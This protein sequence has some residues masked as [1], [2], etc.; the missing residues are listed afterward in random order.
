MEYEKYLVKKNKTD[1][2]S[3]LK[4]LDENLLKQKMKEFEV[5][6]IKKLQ[7]YI[8]ETF[9]SCLEMSI[10][11][12]FTTIYFE[13]LIKHE[14]SEWMSAYEQDIESLFVFVY[15]NGKNY[16]YYIPDELKEIINR[17]FNNITDEAKF[18]LENAANTPIIKD[19]N[20]LLETLT[21]DDLKS[22]GNLLH[23]NRLSK[24]RKKELVKII[25][26]ALTNKDK[27]KDLI[28]RFVDKEFDL[29]IDLMNNKGTIQ[30]NNISIE[31]YHFLYMVGLV[32]LF[33]RDNKFYISMT[34]DI[35][36]VIKK[37]NLNE[38]KK[39]IAENNKVYYMVRSMI[40]LYG[41]LPYSYLDY[42]YSLYY[43]NGKQLET[44]SNSLL[45]CERMDNIEIIYIGHEMYFIHRILNLRDTKPFLDDIILREKKI[46]K[47][48]IKLN[49]LLKYSDYN[50]YEQTES[51]NKLKKY[52]RE[53]HI[54]EDNI[55]NII[56][57]ISDM[58]RL[59]NVFVST[60]IEMFQEYGVNVTEKNIQEIIN[61]L[62]EIYNNSRIWVNN[63]WTPIEMRKEYK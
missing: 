23:I 12:P 4:S 40:E 52:L 24:V 33:R 2:L 25:Y 55:E 1:L 20:G 29:L 13:K 3:S 18:N 22:I 61:Y 49:E 58:Y 30:N 46:K 19:L 36:N 62:M 15:D 34:D 42:Y 16:S 48:P 38:V 31:A 10:D 32:F 60:S 59:G 7:E 14:N 43:G 37:I 17:L 47:K 35:Y 5:E 50:Y 21:V 6:N 9:K 63:G 45:F 39:I 8:I 27:L 26:K 56:K 54:S 57:L 11:D 51:K 53:E 28:E 44:P 41:I